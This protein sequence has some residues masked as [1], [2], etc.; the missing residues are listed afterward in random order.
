MQKIVIIPAICFSLFC[1]GQ[2]FVEKQS[3]YRFAQLTMGFDIQRSFGGQTA[4]LDANGNR[5]R[6]DLPGVTKP[7]IL[8]GGTH[9]WGHADFYIAIPV[10]FPR[11]REEN[12][13][14][15]F[16]SGVETVFKY[17]PLKIKNNQIRP[18]LGVS[19][20]PFYFE[21]DNQ[22]LPEAEGPQLTHTSVPLLAGLTWN[23]GSHL[24]ELG[25]TWNY[26]NTQ[27]YYLDR[28]QFTDIMTPPVLGTISY[29][30]M[31]DT[32]VGA[33]ASWESGRTQERITSL[34]DQGKLNG[35]FFGVGLSSA[36]WIGESTYNTANSPFISDY[37]ISLL[38]DFGLGYY[39]HKIDMNVAFSYRSYGASIDAYGT[40]QTLKR[41]SLG[42]EATK[43]LFD[44]QG[45]DPFV[46]PVISRE[47]LK[48]DERIAGAGEQNAQ[49]DMWSYG[50]TFGW[51]IR[52]DRNQSIILRTNLR[53]FPDLEQEI[54]VG[55]K[56][57]FKTIEFNFIQIIL[58]PNRL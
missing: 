51:D 1:N 36:W 2:I 17:Y 43:Y 3:R 39:F 46:G 9:F 26:E 21:H 50:L 34:A 13:A 37:G 16:T 35:F 19:L 47:Q 57:S 10:A 44:Y 30:W 45:F 11:V 32:T 33:E 53:W 6:L 12:Q 31:I 7:R 40:R 41:R 8:I 54:N 55:Q 58:F 28:A 49:K 29:K 56:I 4:Y 48:F 18:Y 25:V 38:P 20:A 5:Q 22:Y 27:K 14:I 23:R 15:F 42:L 24:V 52:P